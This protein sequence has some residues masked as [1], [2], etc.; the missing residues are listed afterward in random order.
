MYVQF[1]TTITL[2]ILYLFY[3]V[4]QIIDLKSKWRRSNSESSKLTKT[5]LQYD[6][7]NLD[8]FL[9]PL[10]S[11][12]SLYPMQVEL[13]HNFPFKFCH[14]RTN[15]SF[16]SN[17]SVVETTSGLNPFSRRKM[18]LKIVGAISLNYMSM[19]KW[20]QGNI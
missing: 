14:P 20:I 9:F 12:I 17:E 10:F 11:S 13:H 4:F 6:E 15:P 1:Y 5:S 18:C 3:S 2:S 7:L 19:V 8:F 16:F